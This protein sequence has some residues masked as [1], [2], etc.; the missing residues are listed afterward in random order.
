MTVVLSDVLIYLHKGIFM[1]NWKKATFKLCSDG[2]LYK[3]ID[4]QVKRS[5]DL[6]CVYKKIRV[7]TVTTNCV[8]LNDSSS[9][10]I[11]KSRLPNINFFFSQ[12]KSSCMI[13]SEI[14]KVMLIE[15][16]LR[17]RS[18]KSLT[19]L[20]EKLEKYNILDKLHIK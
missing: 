16:P 13:H 11:E 5:I 7:K 1:D 8:V 6:K 2:I 4:G 20:F 9:N 17:Q 10:S 3:L 18:N 19:L 14:K 15:I 12:T